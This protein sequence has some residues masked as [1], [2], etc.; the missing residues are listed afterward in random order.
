MTTLTENTRTD[1]FLIPGLLFLISISFLSFNLSEQGPHQDELDF[2]YAYSV[3]YFSLI[4]DGDF[5]H[6]CWNGDGECDL[7]SVTGCNMD[8]H[9]VTTHGFV[10]HV[11][12]GTG[13]ALHG[14]KEW[15]SYAPV[16]PLCKPHTD[17][18]FGVNVP[19]KSE[20]GAARFFSPILGSLTVVLAFYIGKFLFNRIT[21]L[22]FGLLLLFNSLW[23]AYS[24][25]IMTETYIYFFM[26]LSFFLLLYSFKEQGKIRYSLLISSAVIF[27]IA[28]DT[29]A[30]VFMFFPMFILTIFLRN[31]INQKLSKKDFQFKNYFPK[32]L[33]ISSLYVGI[34]FISII[35]TLPFYW[36]GPI[37]QIIFQK[38]SLDAYNKEMSLHMPWDVESKL[39]IRFL[40]TITVSFVPVIDTYYN[41]FSSDNIPES[42]DR[43]N[44][45]SSIPLS[46]LFFTGLG[47]LIHSIKNKTV[48]G[49]ELIIILW[50]SS[51]FLFLSTMM[52]SYSTSR[53]FVMMFL[54]IILVSSYGY[55]KF[56]NS[57]SNRKIQ[58]FS[59]SLL[60]VAHAITTLVYWKE[61]F[62][63]PSIIWLDP[64]FIKS[65]VAASHVEVLGLGIIF[66]TFFIIFGLTKIKS[67][68]KANL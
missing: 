19:E 45:F 63:T 7:L 52:E 11:L 31:S 68:N 59:F 36:I 47:F 2:F 62:Y 39:H 35:V 61:I 23:F 25:T 53:F 67:I 42:V 28:F 41:F 38:E 55:W 27:G 8:D 50:V 5:F 15:E 33:A 32:S 30:I 29:K 49:S 17:P 22:S 37:D 60:I 26:I 9:W 13:I 3:V 40:S 10:K 43:A 16:P 1:K 54:P 48:T 34:L 20:L 58:I 57:I 21:G 46:I 12:V 65:Q 18:D 51:I 66:A 6:P 64:L 56:F 24:R 4:M 44:N 14:E